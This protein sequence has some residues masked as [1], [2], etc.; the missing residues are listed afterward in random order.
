[1]QPATIIYMA[2][3]TLA[4]Y[5]YWQSTSELVTNVA[6]GTIGFLIYGPVMLIG[7]SALDLVPKKARRHGRRL[8][9]SVR[10]SDRFG[11]SG[12]HRHGLY[13]PALRLGRRLRRAHR[14]LRPV[15]RL[16]RLDVEPRETVHRLI[17]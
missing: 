13:L 12:Q 16:Q 5:V 4:V 14:R 9:R 11:D 1:M 10:L 7:V 3:V 15:D 2:L 6:M 17:L 8:H